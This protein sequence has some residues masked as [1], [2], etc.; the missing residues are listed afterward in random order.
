M[1]NIR[2]T[3]KHYMNLEQNTLNKTAPA[4]LHQT[5]N[6]WRQ[7]AVLKKITTSCTK[8]W[9]LC[10]AWW[11]KQNELFVS[12]NLYKENTDSFF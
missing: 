4:W 5:F 8:L 9:L 2:P 12:S 6:N 7:N 1:L 3:D 11:K 10:E